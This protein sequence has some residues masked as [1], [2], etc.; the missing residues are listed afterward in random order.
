MRLY[1]D[2]RVAINIVHKHHNPVQHNRTKHVETDRHFIKEKLG[3]GLIC[4]LVVT[5][6]K[7]LVDVLTKSLSK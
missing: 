7:Q 3:S 6:A 5:T 1:H 2:N 4:I